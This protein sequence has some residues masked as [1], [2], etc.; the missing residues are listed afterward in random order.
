MLNLDSRI[1]V[2]VLLLVLMLAALF[3]MAPSLSAAPPDEGLFVPSVKTGVSTRSVNPTIVRSR[4]VDLKL[5]LFDSAIAPTQSKAAQAAKT[6]TLNLFPDVILTATLDKAQL[7]SNGFTWLGRVDGV[8]N[9]KVI[10]TLQKNVL[11]GTITTPK[12][13]YQVRYAGNNVHQITQINPKAFPPDKKSLAVDKTKLAT[14][15]AMQNKDDGS[16]IDIL[17]LYTPA[18]KNSAVNE[19][20]IKAMITNAVLESNTVLTDS[21]INPRVTLLDSLEIAY[22]ESG[23][24][25]TDLLRLQNPS[26]GFMDD[27]I[28][29]RNKYGADVVTLIVDGSQYCGTAF[30]IMNPVSAS[31]APYAFDIVALNC[32]LGNYTFVHELGHLMSARH[33][34][35]NDP[36]DNAPYTYNHGYVVPSKT[37]RTIM[38]YPDNC[39]VDCP[40]IG[41]FSNPDL[42]YNGE[43]LGIPE[44]QP[45]A[46]D[47]RKTLN[48]TAPTVANFR[49]HVTSV[50]APLP[51]VLVSPLG[52]VTN[53]QPTYTWNVSQN[54]T[55]YLLWVDGPNGNLIKQWYD[56]AQICNGA[57]CSVV[58]PSVLDNGLYT[59]YVK[60]S[61]S[62]GESGWAT[63]MN[64]TINGVPNAPTLI[65]P[66]GEVTL[67]VTF[68][69][70]VITNATEY[71]LSIGGT[72]TSVPSG[73]CIQSVCSSTIALTLQPGAYPWTA[74]ACNAAGCSNPSASLTITIPKDDPIA[75][76]P[77]GTVTQNP[78]PLVW[79][80]V[81]SPSMNAYT[82]WVKGVN[83]VYENTWNL[84]I[85]PT[86]CP[87]GSNCTFTPTAP[88]PDGEYT[89]K[90]RAC[91]GSTCGNWSNE[92]KF[93]LSSPACTITQIEPNSTLNTNKPTFKWS[94]TGGCQ[95]FY[96]W[97]T[98]ARADSKWLNKDPQSCVNNACSWTPDWTYPN[99]KFSWY[100][101]GAPVNKWFG[102]MNFEI[103]IGAPSGWIV[104]EAE[105]GYG[106]ILKTTN[107]GTTWVRQ[108]SV[109]QIPKADLSGVSAVDA[110]T[111][112]ISGWPAEDGYGTILRTTDGGATWQRIRGFPQIANVGLI[113]ISALNAQT[114]WVVGDKGVILRTTDGGNTWTQQGQDVITTTMAFQGV[115]ALDAQNVWAVG[116]I[117]LS[118]GCDA[119]KGKCLVLLHTTNGGATWEFSQALPAPE[120]SSPGSLLTVQAVDANTVWV[121]G[122]QAYFAYSS[123]GGRSWIRKDVPAMYD[124]N[125]VFAADRNTAWVT[126]DQGGVFSTQDRGDSWNKQITPDDAHGFYLL[127]VSAIDRQNLWIVGRDDHTGNTGIILYTADGGQHWSEQTAPVQVGLLNVSFNG[128]PNAPTLI[129]PSGEVTLPVTFKWYVITNA[130]E[131][132][133]SIGGT[134]TSVPSGNCIQSVCSSTIAL[135]LQPGA[136]PWTAQACNAA[137]CS[138]PSASLTITIPKDDPIAVSPT[139]TVTQN[140]PPLVWKPV[141]SPS[142]N[143]YTLWVKGVNVVY[144]NTWNLQI[145][146]TVC[147]VGSNCTFTPTAPFPDGEYTWKVRA[148]NGSTCGNWSNE[149][150]FTLSSPACTITQIEPN[151]TLNTNKPTFKWSYTGGCQWFYVWVTGAR[152][153]SKWLNKDP[154]SCV[155]NACSW[156]PDWTYPNGKFSWYVY[157]SPVNKWFGP[158]N[159]EITANPP[160]NNG[161]VSPPWGNWKYT[162]GSWFPTGSPGSE[163]YYSQGVQGHFSSAYYDAAEYS[164]LD[165]QMTLW[166]Y[167]CATCSHGINVRGIP[168]SPDGGWLNAYQFQINRR[169]YFS[170][171]RGVNDQWVA[172]Q[173]WTYTPALRQGDNWNTLRVLAQGSNLYYYING[174][175][176]WSG[177]DT[178]LTSGKVGAFIAR[179]GS[180]TTND[181]IFLSN[182]KLSVPMMTTMSLPDVNADQKTR[183]AD[184]NKNKPGTMGEGPK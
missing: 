152:A 100:V 27:A 51:P 154:Q 2:R 92:L 127:R 79:K 89:W 24:F 175:L 41:Y 160:I 77:T 133:L 147:P 14:T 173:N 9:S 117:A 99:G 63:P 38:A 106:T 26:D 108:G 62:S 44:G 126:L 15:Q 43:A 75:V 184:A 52:A 116:G 56:A 113:A 11:V 86:V 167:G 54:A 47:N 172:L 130:T 12:A 177:Y 53:R 163:W 181:S 81:K 96:V 36:T 179:T 151:S 139:G 83:V 121:V 134:V 61:N 155:N 166:R 3:T 31:F 143:A 176:V 5:N 118:S 114:A 39:P 146:P 135:T 49:Q 123:D 129:S 60:A 76:S 46:A 98:G 55:T 170:V 169:G 136:Y 20:N 164:N 115:F 1:T 125:G 156:T 40:R 68:K 67:P 74:Q 90:V 7:K 78:P 149:L 183:N 141:K 66:A 182:A 58:S 21:Q 59:W 142:M 120:D 70:Y 93:T 165:Y 105:S 37:A 119:A 178:T 34:W 95:W 45:N 97:V 72:V 138:N 150:K 73:N 48:N 29:L 148:C 10:F 23:D 35:A 42:T 4:Y 102:P 80:P 18:A 161:F 144:E 82:L 19:N 131:Y 168:G 180:S 109:G 153:D 145:N 17:V 65:S 103:K 6:L 159:F 25:D 8:A 71:K 64:F 85:N 107:G 111:V 101:Y 88:F 32:L 28:T 162:K 140:P 174:T 110:N 84:Q 157:G 33:D 22:S 158:M 94:Y 137:G 124:I 69:W 132:K 91:N 171:W 112:W 122:A 57:T 16:Q 30:D 13:V 87:V 50:P 104:G 128:V